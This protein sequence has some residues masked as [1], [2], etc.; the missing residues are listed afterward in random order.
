MR[1]L[2]FTLLTRA[3]TAFS[4]KAFATSPHAPFSRKLRAPFSEL[5][6]PITSC[7]FARSAETNGRPI[8]PVAPATNT[9]I[10]SPFRFTRSSTG[11][12]CLNEG[13]TSLR[14]GLWSDDNA[15]NTNGG[16]FVASSHG[17]RSRDRG[18]RDEW[19]R[20]PA[21]HRLSAKASAVPTGLRRCPCFAPVPGSHCLRS[22]RGRA[23][24]SAG[25][26]QRERPHAV[27]VLSIPLSGGR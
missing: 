22:H 9:F 5:L 20:S 11:P 17:T 3:S 26:G 15:R 23:A 8:A 6:I 14:L 2:G 7:P 13:F 21:L 4:S 27:V 24:R 19:I 18:T 1:A 16:F 25:F 10:Y 12:V